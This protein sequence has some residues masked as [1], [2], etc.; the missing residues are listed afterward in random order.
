MPTRSNSLRA[1]MENSASP[2]APATAPTTAVEAETSPAI[3]AAT[4]VSPPSGSDS[5]ASNWP[6]VTVSPGS[7]STSATFSPGRSERTDVSSRGIRMPDT[8]TIL[9]KQAFAALSTVT[10]APFGAGLG[11]LVRGERGGGEEEEGGEEG[12]EMIHRQYDPGSGV[13]ISEG[14]RTGQATG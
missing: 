7:A 1:M 3:G 6:A 9:S 11:R 10:A 2:L 4:S 13:S 5:R 12:G 14:G 8:S